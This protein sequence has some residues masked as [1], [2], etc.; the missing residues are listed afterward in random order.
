M[1]D[2]RYFR[3]L[4]HPILLAKMLAYALAAKAHTSTATTIPG[5]LKRAPNTLCWCQGRIEPRADLPGFGTCQCCGTYVNTNPPLP[6]ELARIYS[7]EN[8]WQTRSRQ[9]GM[10][11]IQDRA[12]LYQVD[13]RLKA[14]LALIKKYSKNIGSAVE[15]GCSPG[16]LLKSLQAQGWRCTGVEPD[17]VTAD[18]IQKHMAVATVSGLFPN[19]PL[20]VCDLF[21]AMDTLEHSH[22][23]LA[24]MTAAKNLLN[25][26]GI[27]I[28]Q[29]PIARYGAIVPFPGRPDIFDTVEHFHLFTDQ[30]MEMLA[31]Q[32]GLELVSLN[33]SVWITGEVAVFKKPLPKI[34][35]QAP[36]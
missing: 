14:W 8:Y 36:N 2:H 35:S 19:V 5:G 15:I 27:A 6:E 17:R 29:C 21:L 4:L 24:F 13:G 34:T 3:Y 23:P 12:L 16:I 32:S 33:E 18:W 28:I 10:L 31:S 20:P 26:G 9:A 25:P 1:L 7:Y 22:H 11:P 30:A